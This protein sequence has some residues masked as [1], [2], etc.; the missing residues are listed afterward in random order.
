MN[1]PYNVLQILNC[2]I[3]KLTIKI[4][5]H[6]LFFN[7]NILFDINLHF[8]SFLINNQF[9]FHFFIILLKLTNFIYTYLIFKPYKNLKRSH[10]DEHNIFK[11][12]FSYK[13]YI[14]IQF[15]ETVNLL[16]IIAFQISPISEIKDVKGLRSRF[17]LPFTAFYR[18]RHIPKH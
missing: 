2:K 12:I 7:F 14:T 8:M 6:A 15:K 1:N 4:F 3:L 9:F 13:V 17:Y 18:G 5:I 11:Y 16:R 10:I